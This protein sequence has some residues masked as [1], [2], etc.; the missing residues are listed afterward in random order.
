MDRGIQQDLPVI[1]QLIAV[2]KDISA[3]KEDLSR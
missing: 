1:T 3:L 2:N